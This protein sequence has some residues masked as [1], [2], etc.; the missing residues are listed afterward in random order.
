MI[1]V[2]FVDD[3]ANIL[4]GLQRMLRP[5][6]HEWAM[7]FALG[8]PEALAALAG[9]D[10]DVVVTDMR[11]PGMTGAQLLREVRRRHPRVARIVLSGQSDR[12]HLQQLVDVPHEY[13]AKPCDAD[14]LKAA[15][16]R[17]CRLNKEP[18]DE[19]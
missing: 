1:R 4:G 10:F 16:R 12:E 18:A 11:M 14:V 13:L 7:T 5:L 6:R 19:L 3:E 8:G 9:A 17:I 15:V 2:L